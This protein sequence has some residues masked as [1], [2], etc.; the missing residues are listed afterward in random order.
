MRGGEL[1]TPTGLGGEKVKIHCKDTR[2]TLKR[3]ATIA[4]P[5]CSLGFYAC[6]VDFDIGMH[7]PDPRIGQLWG[8]THPFDVRKEPIERYENASHR[9]RKKS[10]FFF[11]NSI[12]MCL[13]APKAMR[14]CQS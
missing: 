6:Y 4:K 13:K 11:S 8:F 7:A 5:P 2:G 10:M 3:V 9:N 12:F 1:F 14:V